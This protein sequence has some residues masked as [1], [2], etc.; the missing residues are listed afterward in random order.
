[1]LLDKMILL[2][3]LAPNSGSSWN[4]LVAKDK[5]IPKF[6]NEQNGTYYYYDESNDSLYVYWVDFYE[7]ISK[8]EV[9]PINI[10][11]DLG[12]D[13]P[14][15]VSLS[16]VDF[17]TRKMIFYVSE[18]GYDKA[19]YF[20]EFDGTQW[21]KLSGVKDQTAEQVYAYLFE[22]QVYVFEKLET[23]SKYRV[24]IS[25]DNAKNFIQLEDSD[26][27][28]GFRKDMQGNTLFYYNYMSVYQNMDGTF[29]AY[30]GDYF[31]EKKRYPTY[32]VNRDCIYY[33]NGSSL[34]KSEPEVSV[35][36]NSK[37]SGNIYIAGERIYF[38][39]THSYTNAEMKIFN[40]QGQ[41]LYN[42]TSELFVGTNEID[43]SDITYNGFSIV[44]ISN[45]YGE[46]IGLARLIIRGNR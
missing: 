45:S 41:C 21:E 3:T 19:Y 1:M 18:S 32:I 7:G 35:R 2:S 29:S 27:Y 26:F 12:V 9:I 42:A 10:K 24:Y 44:V 13:S 37:Y 25:K 39:S 43:I 20:R 38:K 6:I 22:S 14:Y 5:T 16:T 8:Q 23:D 11:Q 28:Y 34:Y 17:V 46:M 40:L 33:V 31:Q 15:R 30:T 4:E 36:E